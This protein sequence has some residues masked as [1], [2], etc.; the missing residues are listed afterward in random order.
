MR[1]KPAAARPSCRPIKA[2][3]AVMTPKTGAAS[4]GE[5]PSRPR[6]VPAT[7]LSALNGMIRPNTA[8][9]RSSSSGASVRHALTM[10]Y[11]P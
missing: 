7:T 6:L 4:H 5:N 8:H 2:I 10:R 3:S 1:M 9:G 11:K